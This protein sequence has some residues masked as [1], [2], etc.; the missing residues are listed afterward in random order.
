MKRRKMKKGVWRPKA[1]VLAR[2]IA[3]I[4]GLC[5]FEDNLRSVK[6][7]RKL[8]KEEGKFTGML[9]ESWD[10]FRRDG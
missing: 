2:I 3:P 4:F 5:T 1:K 7:A 8:M 6:R 10:T 9:V